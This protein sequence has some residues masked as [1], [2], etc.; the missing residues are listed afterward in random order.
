MLTEQTKIR[1]FFKIK[2]KYVDEWGE[3]KMAQSLDENAIGTKVFGE[4]SE[5]RR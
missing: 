3:I 4:I 2:E 5:Y 1:V